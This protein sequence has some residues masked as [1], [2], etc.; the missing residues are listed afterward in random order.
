VFAEEGL[1]DAHVGQ[2]AK[3]AGMA[4]GTLYNYYKDRDA[5]LAA[6]LDQR[7]E[8]LFEALDAAVDALDEGAPFREQ[9][10]SFVHAYFAF[11]TGHRPFLKILMEGELMHLQ[12][13]F[14]RAAAIH[15]TCHKRLLQRVEE[16]LGRAVAAGSVR[17]EVATLGPWLVLGMMRGI[18]IRDLR[19]YKAYEP[20]DASLMVDVLL[21]GVG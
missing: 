8:E 19:H 11:L 4:V 18:A 9:L 12:S 13:T 14:P 5:L 17:P 3:R 2:I 15:I 6:L 10:L 20:A 21:G 16:L 1:R 7:R